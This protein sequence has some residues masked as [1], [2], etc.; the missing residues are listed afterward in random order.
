V[1]KASTDSMA[2]KAATASGSCHWTASG[3]S[4]VPHSSSGPA[5]SPFAARRNSRPSAS[6]GGD[7]AAARAAKT[8]YDASLTS[9][10]RSTSP[11]SAMPA[12]ACA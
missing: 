5:E 3:S 6:A 11:A 1:K 9:R 2:R 8:A 12:T 10:T 4:L 7:P